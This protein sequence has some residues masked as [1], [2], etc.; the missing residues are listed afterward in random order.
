MICFICVRIGVS[1]GDA[2]ACGG[3]AGNGEGE[4]TGGSNEYE[5]ILNNV[6]IYCL[7]MDNTGTA[8]NILINN[9]RYVID[10]F[11]VILM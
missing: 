9:L 2:N 5:N 4:G 10:I 1:T 7:M 3:G 6:V 11:I 8:V